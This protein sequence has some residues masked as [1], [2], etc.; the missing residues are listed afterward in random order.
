LD[1]PKRFLWLLVYY[2]LAQAQSK[3]L[4]ARGWPGPMLQTRT[5]RALVRS[6]V[7]GAYRAGCGPVRIERVS[8]LQ[9]EEH[10]PENVAARILDGCD[11]ERD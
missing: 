2:S 9:P 1:E 3:K 4:E 8:A 6:Y 11:F 10:K 7:S 5:A